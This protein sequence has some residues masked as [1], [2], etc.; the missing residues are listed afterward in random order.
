MSVAMPVPQG[1]Y[2]PAKRVGGLIFTAGMTPR[3]DG[4]LILTGP[5]RAQEP[6][7]A[8]RE[9]V[10]LACCNALAA[11]RDRLEGDEALS[12]VVNM[13]VFI[14]AEPGFSAHAK[15]ADFASEYLCSE[16][17]RAGIGARTAI[18]VATLPG[19]APVEIQLTAAV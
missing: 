9:A 7:E 3:R 2:L 12:A 18:G 17:G 14:M 4:E 16:L 8:Y 6:L 5:V 19:N 13:F 15:L 11:A 10:V 1:N